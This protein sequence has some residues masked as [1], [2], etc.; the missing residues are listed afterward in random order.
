[1]FTT[2]DLQ[3]DAALKALEAVGGSSQK[4]IAEFILH[5]IDGT[6]NSDWQTLVET[7]M[8]LDL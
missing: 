5:F 8:Q 6:S 4:T 2:A 3:N 1:M 7:Y